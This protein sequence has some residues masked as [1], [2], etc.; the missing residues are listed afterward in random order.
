MAYI[1]IVNWKVFQHYKQRNPPWIKLY[2]TPLDDDD[3]DCLPDDSKLLFFCLLMFASRRD[4]KINL[5]FAW[6]Q[7]KLPIRKKIKQRML[8]PLIDVGF[9]ACKHNDS[10]MIAGCKQD[11]MPE[12]SR[13][14][15][16]KEEKKRFRDFVFLTKEEHKKLVQRYGEQPTQKLIDSLNRYIGQSGKKYKSH[17]FTLL[18]FAKRDLLKELP[19]PENAEERALQKKTGLEQARK[20]ARDEYAGWIKEAD[21]KKLIV[22]YKDFLHLRW[23]VDELRPD[24]RA[25]A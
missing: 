19:T 23:L 22:F 18:N 14:E 16:R 1:E 3:F 12:K 17:Y 11:A 10:T 4:N 21:D 8:Q 5:D 2:N 25:K 6:L 13:V 20:K 24:I 7:K 15:E 9:I